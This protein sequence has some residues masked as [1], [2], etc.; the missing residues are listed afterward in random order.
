MTNS[1]G[2][3]ILMLATHVD[4]LLWACEPEA[5]PVVD[6]ILTSFMCGKIEEGTFRYCG[7]DVEQDADFNI[8]ITCRSS[9]MKIQKAQI[10]SGRS[11]VEPLNDEDKTSMKSIAGSL[12]WIARQCRPDL[13][14]R[15]SRVQAASS[16]G[17][18]ADL[19]EANK[20][21]DYA[22]STSSRGL[23]FRSG[24]L[25]WDF[26]LDAMITC[27][28]TDASHANESEDMIVNGKVSKEPHRS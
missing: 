9:T 27:V 1:E 13:A 20:H 6:K 17:C 25:S 4:D 10:P 21:V 5:Q 22:I 3:V 16:N 28:I 19:K 18:V 7:K 2:K 12:A 8:K 11:I 23:T 26:S 14:Y 24:V 15:I